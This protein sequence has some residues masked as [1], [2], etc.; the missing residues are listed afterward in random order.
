MTKQDLINAVATK[1][2]LTKNGAAAALAAVLDS[3]AGTLAKGGKVTITGFGTFSVSKRNARMG[4]NPRNPSQKIKI[5][6]MK[7][8][9]FKSGKS[10]KEAVRG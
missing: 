3:I 6:A 7:T 1:A 10:L 8:P 4:V 5:P 9:H 2:K